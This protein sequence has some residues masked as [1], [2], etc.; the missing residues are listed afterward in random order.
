[1][2]DNRIAFSPAKQADSE[3]DLSANIIASNRHYDSTR[4]SGKSSSIADELSTRDHS[5]SMKHFTPHVIVFG[6]FAIG[7]GGIWL[8]APHGGAAATGWLLGT[9]LD[10]LLAIPA[11]LAGAKTHRHLLLMALLVSIALAVTALVAAISGRSPIAA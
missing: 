7:L 2:L 1:M 11:L 8:V 4:R 9:M 3:F 10:P 5:L 6:I